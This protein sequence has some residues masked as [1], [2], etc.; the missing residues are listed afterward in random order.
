MQQQ[1]SIWRPGHLLGL[2]DRGPCEPA[3]MPVKPS[4]NQAGLPLH[5]SLMSFP[6]MLASFFSLY[7]WASSIYPV[8]MIK[9]GCPHSSHIALCV[10]VW[11][12]SFSPNSKLLGE[13]LWPSLGLRSTS[14]VYGTGG[15]VQEGWA[16]YAPG[17]PHG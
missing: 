10:T 5:P 12:L 15:N 8:P 7:R 1:V 2:Q 14:V 4:G 13:R 3:A 6:P 17:E 11:L 16:M 9:A